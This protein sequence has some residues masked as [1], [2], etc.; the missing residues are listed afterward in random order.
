MSR[1]GCSPKP[2]D[3]IP[4]RHYYFGKKRK[5]SNFVIFEWK[6]RAKNM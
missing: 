3:F 2:K 1:G 4:I 5:V 6:K